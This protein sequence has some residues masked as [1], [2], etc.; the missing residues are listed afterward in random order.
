VPVFDD[1]QQAVVGEQRDVV[2]DR[3]VIPVEVR[4][5]RS[6]ALA[7]D[8]PPVADRA[9][10]DDRGVSSPSSSASTAARV[11][12]RSSSADSAVMGSM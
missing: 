4:R 8:I 10:R 11:S 7:E 2:V 9:E 3:A 1:E 6:D 5:E 12:S